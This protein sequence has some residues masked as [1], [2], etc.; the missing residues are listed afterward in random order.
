MSTRPVVRVV[1][2]QPH[3]FAFGGFEVQMIT[4][5]EAARA[6]GADVAPLDFWRREPDFDVLHLWGLQLQHRYT[7]KWAR[8][9][10]KKT[11]LSVLLP[12]P[13]W[14]SWLRHKASSVVG[15]ARMLKSMLLDID[16]ITVVNSAQKR[17]L[18]DTIGFAAQKVSI[19]PNVVDD[20][21]FE[22]AAPTPEGKFGIDNYVLCVGNICRRKNQLALVKACQKSSVPLLLVGE[23]LTGEEDYGRALTDAMESHSQL[24]WIKG[25]PS[26]SAQLVDAYRHSAVFAL[27]SHLEQQPISALE[28][29]ACRKPLVLA[30]RPYAKQEFYEN[31]VLADPDSVESIAR[32][33]REALDRPEAH[34]PLTTILERCRREKV[35]EAYL[36]IYQQ[37][38]Q[39][40][41]EGPATQDGGG[42]PKSR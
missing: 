24:R 39:A 41:A 29:A 2:L 8:A 22:A 21:F 33:V 32:A 19:V 12:Y 37:L 30:N 13:G 3:C 31:A 36:S 15:P 17:Y 38:A 11:V 7:V 25:L 20:I 4:A 28:A 40:P 23:V 1:P 10:N 16:C 14:Y 34:R 42:S 6:A 9:G 26:G 18:V 27:P 35:G 5:M